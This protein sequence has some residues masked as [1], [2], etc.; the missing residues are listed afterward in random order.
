MLFSPRMIWTFIFDRTC[1]GADD[2]K[3]VQS[4]IS[5]T[6]GVSKVAR[7]EERRALCRE[8]EKSSPFDVTAKSFSV[9]PIRHC[10]AVEE[11][12]GERLAFFL[13]EIKE[14]S[15]KVIFFIAI[16]NFGFIFICNFLRCCWGLKRTR[17]SSHNI[18]ANMTKRQNGGRRTFAVTHM[19]RENSSQDER[20]IY[21]NDF[22]SPKSFGWPWELFL[23]LTCRQ[24]HPR[25]KRLLS[26]ALD[27]VWHKSA[28]MI[29][30]VT[31]LLNS[32]E[33]LVP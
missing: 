28:F 27:C 30:L 18:C 9:F 1:V 3:H 22:L 19:C 33:V 5:T 24:I 29:T 2:A 32:Q 20:W 17:A 7:K 26:L 14:K 4:W 8:S 12:A 25:T 6:Y 15:Y 21:F 31:G 16:I 10:K 23:W 13:P 11:R